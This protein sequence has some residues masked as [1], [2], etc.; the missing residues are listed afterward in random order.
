[1]KRRAIDRFFRLEFMIREQ[2]VMLRTILLGA[3][4]V[5]T[6]ALATLPGEAQAQPRYR[7]YYG[8][9]YR[10]YYAPRGYYGRPYYRGYYGVPVAVAPAYPYYAPAYP[11]PVYAPPYY[12]P[13]YYGHPAYYHGYHGCDP[14]T[15][16]V[17]GGTAG[18][19]I[20]GAIDHADNHHHYGYGGHYGHYGHGSSIE[21]ALIGGAL[22]A[23]IGSTATHC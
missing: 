16:A 18:A 20:G 9:P 21:G 10:G 14:A 6:V 17:I 13:A 5:S 22:G 19:V 2:D 11:Y 15:G 12:G 3:A 1:L 8:Q 4:A 7:G 23:L